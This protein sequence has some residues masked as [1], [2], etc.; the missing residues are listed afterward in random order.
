MEVSVGWLEVEDDHDESVDLLG[1]TVTGL[2]L[3]PGVAGLL[4]FL[5]DSVMM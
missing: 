3:L 4:M 2:F 1:A 5:D